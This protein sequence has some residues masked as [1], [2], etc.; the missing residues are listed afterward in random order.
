MLE[1][2][3]YIS[4]HENEIELYAIRAQGPGGQ[5]VNKVS[6]AIQLRF[7]VGASSLSED[8]QQRIKNYKDWRMTAGGVIVIKAQR[9]RSQ[10]MNKQDALKRL[11]ALIQKALVVPKKRKPTRLSKAQKQK[12]LDDKKHKSMLKKRRQ[13]P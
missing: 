6:T 12:R 4:I 5:N 3:P 10:L 11:Q 8:I 7:D 1:I 2:N 13:K 9:Y